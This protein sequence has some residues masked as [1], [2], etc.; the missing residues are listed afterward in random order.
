MKFT[1][2]S[3]VTAKFS[4]MKEF[5]QDILQLAPREYQGNYVEFLTEGGILSLYQHPDGDRGLH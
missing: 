5:Y 2:V 4:R 1:H 3:I